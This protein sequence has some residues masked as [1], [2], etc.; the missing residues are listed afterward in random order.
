MSD[1]RETPPYTI[2]ARAHVLSER[3]DIRGLERTG[4]VAIAPLTVK[5]GSEGFA[6]LFRFGAVVLFNLTAEEEDAFFAGL[7][8]RMKERLTVPE[9]DEARVVVDPALDD[10]VD[11]NGDIHLKELS[12]VRLQVVADVL[13]KSVILENDE[14]KVAGV[15]DRIEPLA[16]SLR[17]RGGGGADLRELLRHI[18]DV[19]L[20]EHRLVGR[21]EVAEKPEVLWE[22]PEHERFYAR[23]E[24]E[25]ELSERDRAFNRKLEVISRTASTLLELVENK[26]SLRVEWYIVILIVFEIILTLY[27]LFLRD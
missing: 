4:A 7:A 10:H 26:R 23:L 25:Y 20:T 18:G 21:V 27:E 8:P 13:A 6:V 24:E 19:L 17:S 22:H 11:S 2:L 15:F 16:A 14:N 3:L 9:T 1:M 5:A 12:P